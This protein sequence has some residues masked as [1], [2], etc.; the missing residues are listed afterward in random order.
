MEKL[1]CF[2]NVSG[3][4][5]GVAHSTRHIV[6]YSIVFGK[7]PSKSL[8]V[9]SQ[10]SGY[11]AM[12]MQRNELELGAGLVSGHFTS[13]SDTCISL[14]RLKFFPHVMRQTVYMTRLGIRPVTCDVA[15]A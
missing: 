12:C 15:A 3:A 4:C 6:L 1:V 7:R 13:N 8:W 14:R 5:M 9:V 2:Q 11:R 10:D